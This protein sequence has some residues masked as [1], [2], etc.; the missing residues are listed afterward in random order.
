VSST[1][2]EKQAPDVVE[3][4]RESEW[5]LPSFGK[6][7]FLGDCRLDLIHPQRRLD[8]EAVEQGERFSRG[9]ARSSKSRL[10]RSRSNAMRRFP[11]A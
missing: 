1:V 9:Y 6:Q 4:G 8:A 11:T 2:S 7:L 5:K 10:I 3:A